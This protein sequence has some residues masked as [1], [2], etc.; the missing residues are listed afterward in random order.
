MKRVLELIRVENMGQ[1]NAELLAQELSADNSF[2]PVSMYSIKELFMAA[3]IPLAPLKGHDY[4]V[5]YAYHSS[6]GHRT[7]LYINDEGQIS[8]KVERPQGGV[9]C[10]FWSEIVVFSL[11]DRFY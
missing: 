2:Q 11:T 7:V 10:A 4:Y 5:Y 6:S 3:G 1:G 8:A 9:L